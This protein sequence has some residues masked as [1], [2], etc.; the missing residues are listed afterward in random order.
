MISAEVTAELSHS[1]RQIA[2]CPGARRGYRARARASRVQISATLPALR[3]RLS[4][5]RVD[6]RREVWRCGRRC[7]HDRAEL[8]TAPVDWGARMVDD[9]EVIRRERARLEYASR[10]AEVTLRVENQVKKLDGLFRNLALINGGAIVA[11]FTLIG[12]L[13]KV[14]LGINARL[15]WWSFGAF[16]FGLTITI[17]AQAASARSQFHLSL[18]AKRQA[19]NEQARIFGLPDEHDAKAP[20]ERSERWLRLMWLASAGALAVF[21]L[22]ALL[23]MSAVL[24]KEREQHAMLAPKRGE[25]GGVS[26]GY[27]AP[28]RTQSPQDPRVFA[29][30]AEGVSAAHHRTEISEADS[31]LTW[32]TPINREGQFGLV[33]AIRSM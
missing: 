18:R 13:D 23:A 22:G 5:P 14:H 7:V 9:L 17:A 31:Y 19:W 33:V 29:T 11:L 16:V 28:A 8:G 10:V 2:T 3:R 25:Q 32:H 12:N 26:G 4:P 20:F 6:R 21:F 27:I 15:L 1:S 30:A 24:P